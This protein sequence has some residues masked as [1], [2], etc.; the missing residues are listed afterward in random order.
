VFRSLFLTLSL[1]ALSVGPLAAAE[2]PYR[3]AGIID[4]G[5][6]HRLTVIELPA[7]KH[8]LLREG[9]AVGD[10]RVLEISA[11]WVRLQFP[12]GERRL[13]LMG[14]EGE[15]PRAMPA[16]SPSP[17]P[18]VRRVSRA[19]MERL[20]ELVSTMDAGG[21]GGVAA[22][23]NNLLQLPDHARIVAVNEGT[24]VSPEGTVR[25]VRDAL[26]NG[27]T[28]RLSVAGAPGLARLYVMPAWL[29]QEIQRPQ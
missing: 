10:V 8:R 27:E 19:T 2:R 17:A 18:S 9:E 4:L 14:L 23:F 25:S 29:G 28:T 21:V 22:E 24:M 20:D 12:E 13:R 7:G 3:V 16:T 5:D 1:L 6:G 11:Q 15:G 26:A